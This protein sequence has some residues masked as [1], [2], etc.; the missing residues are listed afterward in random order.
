MDVNW[1]E[2]GMPEAV[3]HLEAKEFGPLVVGIDTKG[4]SIYAGLRKAALEKIDA[5]YPA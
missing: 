3:W 4:R 1:F 5:L 2:M